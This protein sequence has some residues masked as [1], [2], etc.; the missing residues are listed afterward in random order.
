MQQPQ[1]LIF[2]HG[3]RL[4]GLRDDGLGT[5]EISPQSVSF[6][7]YDTLVEHPLDGI[8]TISIVC[9]S[10]MFF[11]ISLDRGAGSYAARRMTSDEQYLE[12]KY[13]SVR[14]GRI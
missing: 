10:E 3:D 7:D 11:T 6:G 1:A 8:G 5:C 9:Y 13:A 2:P 4:G 12:Y 14:G